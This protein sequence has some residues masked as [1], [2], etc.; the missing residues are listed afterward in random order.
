[1]PL[2]PALESVCRIANYR[3]SSILVTDEPILISLKIKYRLSQPRGVCSLTNCS[4]AYEETQS[5]RV[6]DFRDCESSLFPKAILLTF[7]I[8]TLGILPNVHSFLFL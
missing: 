5:N 4:V 7:I 8:F 3:N 6:S 1:M 2:K